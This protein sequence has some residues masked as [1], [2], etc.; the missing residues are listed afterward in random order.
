VK[1]QGLLEGDPGELPELEAL[2]EAVREALGSA[3]PPIQELSSIEAFR[4]VIAAMLPKAAPK[5]IF[6][7]LRLENDEFEGSLSAVKRMVLRL[8]KERGQSG[9][10]VVLR[11]ETEPGDV[12][13]VDFGYVGRLFD[14]ETGKIRK[15][16]A[17]V[18]VLGHSRLMYVSLVFDQRLKT[19]LDEHMKA[20]AYFGGVPAVVVP[21]NL[22]A[23]V[24]KCFFGFN[25]KPDLNRSYRELARYYGFRVDPTPPY[26]PHLKGKVESAVKYVKTNFFAPR[27]LE[28]MAEARPQLED[29]L[30]GVANAR[31]HGTTGKQPRE[32]FEVAERSTLLP[33]PLKPYTHV[34]WKQAK[35]H[36]DSHVEFQR[37]LYSVPF[38]HIAKQ[39]YV[40]AEGNAV[41][42]F[43]A[44]QRVATH[45]RK[46]PRYHTNEA[47][48]PEQRR[49]L[50]HRG[51]Q[52]WQARAN[53]ISLVVGAFIED[54]F[55]AD[56][57]YHQLRAVQSIVT[58]LE[59]YPV[60]RA[61]AA[62]Q[63]AAQFGNFTFQGIRKILVEG[64]DLQATLPAVLYT[65]GKLRSPRF[66]RPM[67]DLISTEG[68][69]HGLN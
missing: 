9:K 44:N 2:Q 61:D 29:W 15:T 10:D 59:Q 24:T 58:H 53:K 41:Q 37:R 60:D 3:E 20:F 47:H 12:A 48:L 64:L 45:E 11:V 6:D 39:A 67:A 27:G 35:V 68:G 50:R 54:V 23:A 28:D 65:H 4:P 30:E 21:D 33:L 43:V 56:D 69:D 22:K 1:S 57:V 55:E 40:R 19:W 31:I 14:V 7:R 51:R 17:F 16:Y 5:A 26:S 42:V 36:P 13:Q 34:V 63:R 49:D 32:V 46:G 66:A 38:R 52:W 18:M 25:E 62:C 8:K